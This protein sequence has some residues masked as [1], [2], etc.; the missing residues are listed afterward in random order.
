MSKISSY[1]DTNKRG[2]NQDKYLIV[3]KI[4]GKDKILFLA[5]FD[6]MGGTD[7]GDIASGLAKALTEKWIESEYPSLSNDVNIVRESISMLI[8]KINEKVVEIINKE[9]I[10]T[11]STMAFLIIRGGEYIAANIG[12]SRIYKFGSKSL[13]ITKDQTQ[14]QMEVDRGNL[15]PEEA[16][17]DK[18]AHKLLQCIGMD[19]DTP[20][21][22]FFKGKYKN[23]DY[24]LLCSDGMYNTMD[25][26]DIE[27]IVLYKDYGT[28]DKLVM[29]ANQ[30]K[31][32]KEKDNITGVLAHI[33]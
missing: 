4:I 7:K 5:V 1:T 12:D 28:K 14:A 33:C 20:N 15:T 19:D 32:N 13:Q 25:L 9:G 6:G 26:E 24:F 17:T 31:D 11:G 2:D 21:P 10:S 29:L 16:K 27:E 23:G 18:R 3:P 8:I 30:A 22:D